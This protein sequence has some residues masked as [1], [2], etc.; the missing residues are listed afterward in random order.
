MKNGILYKN[1]KEEWQIVVPA[2]LINLICQLNHDSITAG[3]LAFEK[4]LHAI[5]SKY[6]WP[7]MKANVYGYCI[8]GKISKV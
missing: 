5:R 3:H 4:T 6:I 1:T 7:D 8:H 2:K